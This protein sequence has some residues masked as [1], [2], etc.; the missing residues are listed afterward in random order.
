VK[1]LLALLLG[2][3][4]AVTALLVVSNGG[5]DLFGKNPVVGIE[6]YISKDVDS[7]GGP[8]TLLIDAFDNTTGDSL[9][10]E[11]FPAVG[12]YR[13]SGGIRYPTGHKVDVLVRAK[14]GGKPIPFSSYIRLQD[15]GL[16]ADKKTCTPVAVITVFECKLTTK[17]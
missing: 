4:C 17:Y 13:S 6:V 7:G 11:E 5:F 16:G 1:R 14:L 3:A 15:G 2:A 10:H 9:H 8:Y 12:E